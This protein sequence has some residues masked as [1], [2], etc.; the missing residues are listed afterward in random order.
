MS[1]GMAGLPALSGGAA[2]LP[3]QVVTIKN[4]PEAWNELVSDD[5]ET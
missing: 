3:A 1:G 5:L 4:Q 2:E